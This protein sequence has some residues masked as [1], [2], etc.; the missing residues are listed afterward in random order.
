MTVWFHLPTI[1][2]LRLL[3]RHVVSI[4][5]FLILCA[6]LIT[7][8]FFVSTSRAVEGINQTISFQGR[9]LDSNGN[10]VPDGYYNIQFKIYEGGSGSA[11]G[12]P[13]GTL[14]WTETYINDN[15]AEGVYVRNGL[16]AAELGS[17]TPFGSSVDW[18]QSTLWLSMNIAGNNNACTTFG[19]A[20]CAADGE[21]LPMKRLT[22]SPYAMNAGMV[23]GKTAQN[24]VQLAQGVQEDTSTN[25]SSIHINKTGTGNFVQLQNAGDDALTITQ[26]GNIAFGGTSDHSITIAP[27]DTD[28]AGSQLAITAGAGGSGDGA[29]GGTLQ[30]QGGAA[31][32]TNG[33][34]G[35]ITLSGG[36]GTGTGANGLVIISTPTFS[37]ADEQVCNEDCTALQSAIDGNGVI[38]LNA[39]E[40]GLTISVGNPTIT[41][42]GRTIYVTA[43]SASQ[44]FTLSLNAGN[45]LVSVQPN[46]T[47]AL[48][49]NGTSWTIVGNPSIN[50]SDLST[51][52]TPDGPNV[53]IG[54]GEDNESTTLLTLDK[55]DGAPTITDDALLGSMYYD[56]TLGKV[57]CYEASGWGDCG[58][59][60]DTFI[61]LS[62]EYANAVTNGT[63]SGTLTS[64]FCSGSLGINNGDSGQPTICGPSE[65]YNLYDWTS[66]ELSAQ[67][68]NIYVTYTLP[69][70]F[71]NF[72]EDSVS[73]MGRTDSLDA[74]VSYQLYRNTSSGLSAC[75]ATVSVSTGAQTAW[76]KASS[77][78]L[79]NDP[80]NC[81]FT[82]GDNIVIKITLSA[83]NDAHAY[84]SNLAF[85]FTN[86]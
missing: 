78:G 55:R 19:S 6:V 11:T 29:A 32:G 49:W 31:G 59:R 23:G 45:R 51:H 10:N 70:S 61:T 67:E 83:A 79:G 73:L 34:G 1:F 46:T 84:A 82:A 16:L 8:L 81:G 20:P 52:T 24:L 30:L 4:T 53:Q 69:G 72:V 27:A 9:L 2:R 48:L 33:N 18:N 36:D 28:T 54:D 39:I 71:D 37:T 3:A 22:T 77:T 14:K 50:T 25:T 21:M 76:Q 86:K 85:T 41:T 5:W 42:A 40:S 35:N 43:S 74:A 66:A 80:A 56:T 58:S 64:D 7:T 13:D 60:P 12:N 68:K 75:G 17:L 63:G 38:A 62:P 44:P 65:T 47:I 26:E 15:N 57:Q